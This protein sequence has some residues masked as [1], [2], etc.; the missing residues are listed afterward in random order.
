MGEDASRPPGEEGKEG[1]LLGR[2]VDFAIADLHNVPGQVDLE[3]ADA[4]NG[5][6]FGGGNILTVAQGDADA[7]QELA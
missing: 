2:E 3:V 5:I 4:Q 7:S 6:I 1:E